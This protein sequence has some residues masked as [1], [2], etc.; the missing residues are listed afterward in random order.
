MINKKDHR[1]EASK[2]L[3]CLTPDKE[4]AFVQLMGM[5]GNMGHDMTKLE[6]V[7]VIDEYINHRVGQRKIV[8]VLDKILCGLLNHHNDLVKVISAGLLDR[9]P[10]RKANAKTRDAVFTK[11]DCY[12][13]NLYAM[14]KI[15][16]HSY[17]DVPNDCIYNM[18]KVGLDTT[19]HGSKVIADAAAIIRKY[20]KTKE[21]E[22]KMNMHITTC[23]TTRADGEWLADCCKSR[24]LCILH[25]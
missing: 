15:T 22:G 12:I 5:M 14:E 21:D 23:L 25:H 13:Y 19:K 20:Q 6:A 7:E 8:Q 17:R 3:C 4:L 11:L 1:K 9:Q 16:W 2:S 18:D 24:L 10:A